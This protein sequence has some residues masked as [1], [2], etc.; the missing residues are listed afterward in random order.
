MGA[1]D[2]ARNTGDKIAGKTKEGMGKLTDDER[3]EAE[4]K[5]DSKKADMKQKGEKIKD[6]FK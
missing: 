2:K 4:G 3:L 1:E 5:K 6:V